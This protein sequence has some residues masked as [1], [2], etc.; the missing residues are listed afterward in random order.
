MESE[1]GEKGKGGER[2]GEKRRD[3]SGGKDKPAICTPLV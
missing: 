3:G 2:R 1:W